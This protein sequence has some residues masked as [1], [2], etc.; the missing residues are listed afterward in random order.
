MK[1]DTN[2]NTFNFSS[3]AVVQQAR[4][5]ALALK[6]GEVGKTP[7]KTGAS[8]LMFAAI[9][10]KDPDMSRLATERHSYQQR[11]LDEMQN[12]A[13]DAQVKAARQRYEKEGKLTINQK[14]I[15][16]FMNSEP[17]APAVP[18]Q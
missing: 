3:L 7:V 10:R 4:T 5:A 11:L 1:K 17:V 6:E 9:K 12:M 8:W 13:F 14:R 18:G 16:D 15:D 2:F